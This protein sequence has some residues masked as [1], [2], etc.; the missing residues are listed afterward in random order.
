MA[1]G[2]GI[3][4][5]VAG[6]A[7]NAIYDQLT[8]GQQDKRTEKFMDIQHKNNKDMM[9]QQ[10]MNQTGLNI[11]GHELQ[12]EMWLKTNYPDQVKQMKK[13]GLNP[14]LMYG[15]KGGGGATT[16]S[17]SGGSASG[18][19]AGLGMA[20]Q[21]K[22]VDMQAGLIAAQTE[23]MKANARD[24]NADA[25]IK[26]GTN[27][28]GR[29][30]IENL[31]KKAENIDAGIKLKA[32]QTSEAKAREELTSTKNELEKL[33]LNK[34]KINDLAPSDSVIIKT[35]KSGGMTIYN[36]WEWLWN[37]TLEEKLEFVIPMGKEWEQWARDF[38][39][40]NQE[41]INKHEEDK[42]KDRAQKEYEE[43]K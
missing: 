20:P 28:R 7:G 39:K 5:T 35:L 16:G 32:A 37:S 27:P 4:A 33:D 23:M 41:I 18:G 31:V 6:V 15:M 40:N 22:G 36:A 3:G 38:Q 19:N 8:M 21:S 25:D 2:S 1:G 29:Q 10:F 13:A 9:Q 11:Q 14:A 34:L 42:L 12:Y 26:E 30:E 43:K 24:T 17:Q